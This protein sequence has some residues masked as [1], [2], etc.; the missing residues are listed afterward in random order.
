[1]LRLVFAAMA[2]ISLAAAA[3]S[4]DP[5]LVLPPSGENSR[6]SEGDFI[7][8]RDGRILFVYTHF[9]TGTGSDFDS[10]YLAAREST[11]DGATWTAEDTVLLPN[12]GELNTMSVSLE[13]L[14]NG[15][16]ALLYLRKNGTDDCRPY[17]RIS[18]DETKT[19][20][21]PIPIA[22]KVGYYVVNNDRLIQHSTGRLIVPTAIHAEDGDEFSGRGK[23]MCFLSDDNGTTWR[24]SKTTLEADEDIETGYQEPGVV[25]NNNGS[26]LMLIRTSAGCLYQ[27]RS[28]DAGE[29]WSPA[30]PTDLKSPV[31]PAT[32]ERVPGALALLLLWNNHDGVPKEL[33]GKRTPLSAAVSTN[34]G[35]TWT[36]VAILEDDPN[37]W[38]CY[39]AMELTN[40]HILLA[41]CA[42]D[43]TQNNGLA[44]TKIARIPRAHLII[45]E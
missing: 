2:A 44:L 45:P 10:A 18:E 35:R 38:Y 4:Q 16:I 39:T 36:P 7:K 25:E 28:D 15:T 1:M 3:I 43:R 42:G 33:E 8:L 19:W 20:S 13:R 26:L 24:R 9:T 32:V 14:R 31:S 37:G 40:T 22:D 5:V 17:L 12:E 6:N 30:Q 29:T 23:A 34:Q 11:D 41:Y 21:D 27:S